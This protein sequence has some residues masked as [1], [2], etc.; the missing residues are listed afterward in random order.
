MA[1]KRK[2]SKKRSTNK[3]TNKKQKRPTQVCL[4]VVKGVYGLSVYLNG[5]RVAGEKPWGGGEVLRCWLI[6]EKDVE[7]AMTLI[8]VDP[9]KVKLI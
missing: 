5:Y 7:T 4:E 8:R 1:A 6:D 3:K 2:A 9:K